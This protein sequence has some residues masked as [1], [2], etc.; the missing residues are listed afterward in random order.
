MAVSKGD[1]IS[2]AQFNGMQSRIATV[3]GNGSGNYGYGQTVTSVQ[4]STGTDTITAAQIDLLRADMAKA[5]THQNGVLLPLR[6]ISPGDVIGADVSGTDITYDNIGNDTV[7]NSDIQ[8]GV[9]DYLDVLDD[10]ETYR[11]TIDDSQDTIADALTDTRTSN[12]NS[13]ITGIYRAS[14]TDANHR[15]HFFNSGGQIRIYLTMANAVS[16]KDTNWQTIITNPGTVLFGHDYVSITGSTTGVTINPV[17]NYELISGATTVFT[18]T[19]NSGVYAENNWRVQFWEEN[20]S[21][22]RFA[23]I[24]E[25]ADTGDEPIVP[26][27]DGGIPGGVDEQITGDITVNVGS[28]R[29]SG[30]N[31]SVVAPAFTTISTLE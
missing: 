12:W 30:S 29:A 4:V 25:D 9:N 20:S 5:Y 14:F 8:G 13:S 23:V 17:G 31:V 28:R 19:G 26:V 21:T 2:A 15:R 16:S 22:I 18:K 6:N 11:F 24:L 27:P 3:L 10:L 7:V 1:L